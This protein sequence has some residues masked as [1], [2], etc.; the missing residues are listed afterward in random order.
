[1]NPLELRIRR[2]LSRYPPLK[3]LASAVRRRVLPAWRRGLAASHWDDRV[4]EVESSAPQGWLDAEMVEREHIRPLVSGDPEVSYLEYFLEK[5]LPHRPVGRLLSLGCGG[6]N[7]ERDLL[8]LGAAQKI[9]ACDESPASIELALRLATEEGMGERL[10]Y[11]VADLNRL[12]LAPIT[13][14]VV[15]AK[16]A[17]H[18]FEALEHVY[19]QVRQGLRPGGLFMFNEFVGPSRFQWTDLQL[20]HMNRLLDNAPAEIK[21]QLPVVAI[22]RPLVADMI[23][24]D[25]SESVRS[26]EIL[27]LLERDFEI[28]ERKDYGGTLLHILFSHV[29]PVVDF[30]NKE[31]VEYLRAAMRSERDLLERGQL[32]SDFTFVVA[33]PRG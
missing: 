9:D 14:D 1:M 20:D 31:H 27:P 6:G 7:L 11:Q 3:R 12:E 10:Q 25:P 8:R 2:V 29:L 24:Q 21:E 23:A 22:R 18:H 26:A 19:G 28:V 4:E 17:L 33:R 32:P 15:I 30:E 5:H 13:Y 16:M